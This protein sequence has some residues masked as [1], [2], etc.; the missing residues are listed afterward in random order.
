MCLQTLHTGPRTPGLQCSGAGGHSGFAL[1]E[2][3]RLF[4]LSGFLCCS[5]LLVF[6]IDPFTHL[7]HVLSNSSLPTETLG[8]LGAAQPQQT[9]HGCFPSLCPSHPSRQAM[10]GGPSGTGRGTGVSSIRV[11]FGLPPT[12][13]APQGAQPTPALLCSN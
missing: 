2:P 1:L 11:I 13:S 3:S 7:L 9:P 4:L 5:F 10:Q 12:A 6:A 8:H